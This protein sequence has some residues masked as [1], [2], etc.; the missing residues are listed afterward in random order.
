VVG[1]AGKRSRFPSAGGK[2]SQGV[3]GERTVREALDEFGGGALGGR[4]VAGSGHD[5]GA[6]EQKRT[7]YCGR[8]RCSERGETGVNFAGG[9]GTGGGERFER[10]ELER[11]RRT[12]NERSAQRGA[13]FRFVGTENK[14]ADKGC[15]GALPGKGG[16]ALLQDASGLGG[17][18]ATGERDGEEFGGL[19]AG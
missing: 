13:P 6:G 18:T 16:R 9:G 7:E 10:G 5:A 8:N 4:I 2:N 15:F 17:G 3:G 14:S 11:C 12:R 19:E 1:G